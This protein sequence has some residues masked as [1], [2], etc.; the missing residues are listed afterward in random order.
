MGVYLQRKSSKKTCA[1]YI[2]SL[3]ATSN[4]LNNAES[5]LTCYFP[6]S[7][8]IS[9]SEAIAFANTSALPSFTISAS[10]N[11]TKFLV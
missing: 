2:H 9:S 5:T 3:S 1:H 7:V 10:N 8:C 4:L 11:A 6:S